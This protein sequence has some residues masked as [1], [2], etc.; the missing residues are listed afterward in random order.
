M[1]RRLPKP[2]IDTWNSLRVFVNRKK[3]PIYLEKLVKLMI[4]ISKVDLTDSAKIRI[5]TMA[6]GIAVEN[7]LCVSLFIFYFRFLFFSLHE[8]KDMRTNHI[9]T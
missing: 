8:D 9:V 5:S 4:S 7:C 6:S 2:R 3:V 1:T